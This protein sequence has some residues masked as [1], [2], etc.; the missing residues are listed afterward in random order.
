MRLDQGHALPELG[1][2]NR[3]WC[4]ENYRT[5]RQRVISN[6]DDDDDGQRPECARARS[7]QFRKPVIAERLSIYLE[8]VG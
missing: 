4:E 1:D 7:S 3:D 8:T 2:T 5:N 6:D